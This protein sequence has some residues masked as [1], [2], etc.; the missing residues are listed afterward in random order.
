MRFDHQKSGGL[1]HRQ[2]ASS[3]SYCLCRLVCSVT[4]DL[5]EFADSLEIPFLETSAKNSTNVEQVCASN[6]SM[7]NGFADAKSAGFYH[8]G[9]RDQEPHAVTTQHETGRRSSSSQPF[10]QSS[11]VWW[12]LLLEHVCEQNRLMRLP[13]VRLFSMELDVVG[14]NA[15]C[16]YLPSPV[17]LTVSFGLTCCAPRLQ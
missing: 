5:Q 2:G 4:L 16:Y 3:R 8:Y 1:H 10:R 14:L 6:F 13:P 12:W 7:F 11:Q 15:I 9:L 17:P